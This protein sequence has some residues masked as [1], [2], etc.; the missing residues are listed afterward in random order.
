M[1]ESWTIVREWSTWDQIQIGFGLKSL[2]YFCIICFTLHK[3]VKRFERRWKI[4]KL[5][6]SRL[7]L[8]DKFFETKLLYWRKM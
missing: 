5:T 7:T 8:Y 3:N 6:L 2:A 4:G 1:D